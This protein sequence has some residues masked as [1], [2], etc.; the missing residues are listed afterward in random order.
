MAKIEILWDKIDQTLIYNCIESM[1]ERFRECI[2]SKD[3]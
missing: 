2:K 1:L 3:E